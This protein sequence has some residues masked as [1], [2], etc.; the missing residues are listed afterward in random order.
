MKKKIEAH[1]TLSLMFKRDGVPPRVIVDNSKEQ[2]LGD[3]RQ[4][5][6]EV[7]CHLVNTEPYSPWQQAA[8]LSRS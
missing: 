6:R 5:C 7:D 8:V 3:F 4:K 2:S 1:E